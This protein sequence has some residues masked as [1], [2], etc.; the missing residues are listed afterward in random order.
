MY[1][2]HHPYEKGETIAAIATPI[3]E[4]GIAVIRIS[5]SQ[6]IEVAEKIYSG[7]LK[8]YQSH[9]LHFGNIHDLR[10]NKIDE[11]LIVVMKA[12]RSYTGEDTV[13]IHCH[14]GSL[15][16]KRVL[17]AVLSAGARAALP[18]EFT[19]TAYMNGKIG[20]TEA[21]A[22][23]SLIGA[24]NEIALNIASAQLEGVLSKKIQGFQNQLIDIAANLEAWV[25]FPEEGL[26]FVPFDALIS[27]L[28][29]T[30]RQI[31]HLAET[32]H[33]GRIIHEGLRLCL[34]GAP[35]VGKSSL[36]NALLGS[37]RSIV[38]DIPGTTRDILEADLRI[39]NLH[40][41]LI[42]TAGLR[43]TQEIVER[44][45]VRRSYQAQQQ[46]DLTLLVLDSSLGIQPIDQEILNNCSLDKLVI[47][48]NKIDLNSSYIPPQDSIP[49]SAKQDLGI[50]KLKEAILQKIWKDGPPSKE[51]V[52][53]TNARH[54]Q[55]LKKA[56][57]AL[58]LVIQGLCSRI[59]PE[60]ISLELRQVLKDLGT[61][62]GLDIAED[63]LTAIF[64]KFC[65]G[66]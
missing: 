28:Q 7:P 60:L 52:I 9:V 31:E 8:E 22:V 64:S 13:E 48:W 44:E 42:D 59:S 57:N 23:Q 25:D 2:I 5:G 38:T 62:I 21:E 45:G 18:G 66:K 54:H 14:G 36:M 43:E 63:I 1:F 24:R 35:N 20:L 6:S 12:P 29:E 47:I 61:I 17:Q 65:I 16:T 51:E 56:L 55:A 58:N 33:E 37:D 11:V 49:I 50:Q 10:G 53:I 41:K 39:G 3:G 19:F 46:A 4:G 26:E 34:L 32:F 27:K 15:I 40:F 30:Y